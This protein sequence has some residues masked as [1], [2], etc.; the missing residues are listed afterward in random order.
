MNPTPLSRI[1]TFR[2]LTFPQQSKTLYD[3][4]YTLTQ[5]CLANLT[6]STLQAER[7]Q[8][9][10]EQQRE[11]DLL[12]ALEQ[13]PIA[14]YLN[15]RLLEQHEPLQS[16]TPYQDPHPA[17]TFRAKSLKRKGKE[18]NNSLM[19]N[20][21]AAC[22]TETYQRYQ[23]RF[24][25]LSA[26]H[27]AIRYTLHQKLYPN[28]PLSVGPAAKD[29]YPRLEPMWGST[30][31][32]PSSDHFFTQIWRSFPLL[33]SHP[34]QWLVVTA[35]SE[36]QKL[37]TIALA[38]GQLAEEG[39]KEYLLRALQ[40]MTHSPNPDTRELGTLV[41]E[42]LEQGRL[43]WIHLHQTTDL[44]TGEPRDIVQLQFQLS[45]LR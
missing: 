2:E 31:E 13:N 45:E 19:L 23:Q 9:S 16:L 1:H 8:F 37:K 44:E 5:S 39:T 17:L 10:T 27:L 15:V 36:T 34:P 4:L 12:N 33:R 20:H 41:S 26:L 35:T 29:S 18:P 3:H 30:D 40:L 38:D 42:A 14:G 21:I 7:E 24:P 43:K 25:A 22:Q 28:R 11:Q 32:T 6:A